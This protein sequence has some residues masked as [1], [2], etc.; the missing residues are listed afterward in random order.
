MNVNDKIVAAVWR[1][2][3]GELYAF[4]DAP[5]MCLAAVRS[6]VEAALE[7]PSH[8]LYQSYLTERVE[9]PSAESPLRW[10]RDPHARDLERSLRAQGMAVPREEMQPGDLLFN[11][12]AAPYHPEDWR[13]EYPEVPFPD[14]PVT[15]GHV[16]IYLG[17]GCLFENINPRYRPYGFTRNNLAITPL[18]DY[19]TFQ[20]E[21]TTVIRFAPKEDA[22]A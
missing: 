15:V 1:A 4:S 19:E 18:D 13:R 9:T 20:G 11:F 2:L 8:K 12:R 7:W 10:S 3:R 16:T 14:N 17:E 21:V 5:G 22:D 6:V